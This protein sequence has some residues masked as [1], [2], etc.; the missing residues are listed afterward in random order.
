MYGL[1]FPLIVQILKKKCPTYSYEWKQVGTKDKEV[2]IFHIF[3]WC[4]RC[5]FKNPLKF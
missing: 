3:K 5:M 2:L 4:K 1:V